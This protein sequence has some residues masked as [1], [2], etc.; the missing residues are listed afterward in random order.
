MGRM[1]VME[2]EL[3]GMKAA[4]RYEPQPISA[5]KASRYIRD[6]VQRERARVRISEGQRKS[7]RST[8]PSA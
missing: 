8:K 2:Q 3:F 5:E 7:L 6:A 1:T 4:K